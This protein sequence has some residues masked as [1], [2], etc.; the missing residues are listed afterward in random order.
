MKCGVFDTFGGQV[1]TQ[2]ARGANWG[3]RVGLHNYLGTLAETPR[4]TL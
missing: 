1:N 4:R 3:I 2:V